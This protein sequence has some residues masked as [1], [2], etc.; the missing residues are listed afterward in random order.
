MQ[1]QEYLYDI[2]A[3]L[4]IFYSQEIPNPATPNND[5]SNYY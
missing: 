4:H 2:P 5:I 3:L 1:K